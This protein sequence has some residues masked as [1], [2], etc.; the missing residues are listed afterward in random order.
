M[1]TLIQRRTVLKQNMKNRIFSSLPIVKKVV[2]DNI[3]QIKSSIMSKIMPNKLKR[4]EILQ[5]EYLIEQ[6]NV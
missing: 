2:N 1:K 6:Q 5:K 3:N 4:D